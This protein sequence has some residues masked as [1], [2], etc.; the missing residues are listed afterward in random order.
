M[1]SAGS[2]LTRHRGL[3]P[4][5]RALERAIGLDRAGRTTWVWIFPPVVGII[6]GALSPFLPGMPRYFGVAGVVFLGVFGFVSMTVISVLYMLAFDRDR[7][8]VGDDPDGTTWSGDSR[9]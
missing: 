5:L 8:Q 9:S 2:L 4:M 1:S 6:T 3:S 7:N